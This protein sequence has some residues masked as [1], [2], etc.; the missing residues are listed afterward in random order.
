[1]ATDRRNSLSVR[2]DKPNEEIKRIVCYSRSFSMD[3]RD[4]HKLIKLVS[5]GFCW[6]VVYG[7]ERLAWDKYLTTARAAGFIG[8]F[9]HFFRLLTCLSPFMWRPIGDIQRPPTPKHLSRTVLPT[10]KLSILRQVGKLHGTKVH[11]TIFPTHPRF[12]HISIMYHG[13]DQRITF[14]IESPMMETQW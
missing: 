5:D 11:V 13:I 10:T 2:L 4:V 1:M 6:S 8:E 7:R 9:S 14:K 3:A 12:G